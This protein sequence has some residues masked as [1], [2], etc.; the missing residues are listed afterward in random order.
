M[1]VDIASMQPHGIETSRSLCQ[2]YDD[3]YPRKR[4]HE[5]PTSAGLGLVRRPLTDLKLLDPETIRSLMLRKA[6]TLPR[7]RDHVAKYTHT[8]T[9]NAHHDSSLSMIPLSG[10]A[11]SA[12]E[13]AARSRGYPTDIEHLL[14]LDIEE[15]MHHT[16]KVQKEQ[17][18]QNVGSGFPHVSRCAS[19]QTKRYSPCGIDIS[20]GH[21]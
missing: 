1:G 2:T 10:S 14:T 4:R 15:L 21:L 19:W 17:Q 20:S 18:R 12:C 5:T 7:S 11:A 9:K 13:G 3:G 16:S 6:G 8:T